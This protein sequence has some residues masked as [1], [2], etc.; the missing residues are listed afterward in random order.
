MNRKMHYRS[1]PPFFQLQPIILIAR[2]FRAID[3]IHIYARERVDI[4]SL[5]RARYLQLMP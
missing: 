4:G 3:I 5:Y 1:P 2:R